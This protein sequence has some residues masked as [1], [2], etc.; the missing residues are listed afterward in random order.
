MRRMV[1][2][3][4]EQMKRIDQRAETDHGIPADHLMD[5]A[6]R[7]VALALARRHGDLAARRILI[8]C[9]KG[10][11]GGDGLTAARHLLGMGVRARV[12][13]LCRASELSGPAAGACEKARSSGVVVEE[14]ADDES[15]AALRRWLPENDLLV[16][17]LLGTGLRGEARGRAREAIEA[18]NG[19]GCDVVSIDVPSGLSGSD[20]L[21]PAI[22]VEADATIALAALKIPHVFPPAMR[23]AGKVEVA[24]IGIPEAA[25]EAERPD[26]HFMDEAAARGLLPRRRRSDH[27]GTY[28]HVLAVAGSRGKSGAAVLLARAALRSGAGLVTVAAPAS[29]QPMIAASV[30][31]AMTVALPETEEGTLARQALG[32]IEA[33]LAGR[34]VLAA[35]PGLGTGAGA[36]EVIRSL[37]AS[38]RK[39][40]VLDADVLNILAGGKAGA[41][42]I[43]AAAAAIVTPHPG[44]AARLLGL[45]AKEVQADRLGAVRRLARE[46]GCCALLKGDRTLTAVPEGTVRVNSTGNPGMATGGSGDALTGIAAAWLAQGLSPL[47]AA[48][49]AAFV[50]G[51]AGDEAARRLG[52]IAMTAGDLIESL[53]AAYL[54]L[55]S[56]R[57]A[58]R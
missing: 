4:A 20:A 50:H 2:L 53:P 38:C 41:R 44:E 40:M 35:G 47:D 1:I 55:T 48:S 23:F 25:I 42:K 39:P 7:E 12:A 37:A 5:N 11:N 18:I 34:D 49:L 31:E 10:N 19:A 32:A 9:G 43:G 24:D 17:A 51:L 30:P 6:G 15:W 14:I 29:A 22:A 27:K 16:D 54:A 3:T 36:A 13:L 8:L 58:S 56:F 33:L 46:M 28:G 21:A 26:L 57:P 52:E 45:T